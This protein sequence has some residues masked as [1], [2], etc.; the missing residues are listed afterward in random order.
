MHLFCLLFCLQCEERL[1]LRELALLPKEEGRLL[2][3]RFAKLEPTYQLPNQQLRDA[4]D[5]IIAASAGL[6]LALRLAGALL[7][8]TGG[9][10][11]PL[12][13]W[14]V[15]EHPANK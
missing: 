10:L 8:S 15:S 11:R 3:R 1:A 12:S 2:F 6:P 13:E 9:K 7:K 4:E 5:A 14:L